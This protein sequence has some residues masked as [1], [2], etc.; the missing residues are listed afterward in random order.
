MIAK[1]AHTADFSMQYAVTAPSGATRSRRVD[2]S[3]VKRPAQD[4]SWQLFHHDLGA[5]VRWGLPTHTIGR[6]VRRVAGIGLAARVE[7]WLMP[8]WQ[9]RKISLAELPG[10]AVRWIC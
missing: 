3:H 4:D 2:L 10:D 9:Y 6:E 5:L 8:Q 7:D 1:I